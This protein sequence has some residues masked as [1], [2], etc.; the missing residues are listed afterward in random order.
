M[1]GSRDSSLGLWLEENTRRR[2]FLKKFV[3]TNRTKTWVQQIQAAVAFH[4]LGSRALPAAPAI[5]R[6]LDDPQCAPCAMI[7]LIYIHPKT[8]REIL[9]L[10]NVLRIKTGSRYGYQADSLHFGAILA[11]G[12][13]GTN[14]SAAIPLLCKMIA[15][16]N[17]NLQAASAVALQRVGVPPETG[18]PLI[19][20][21]LAQAKP[22]G[23]MFVPGRGTVTRAGAFTD[24][25][26][27]MQALERYG[28]HASNALPM[29]SNVAQAAY[30]GNIKGA[31]KVTIRAI[32]MDMDEASK[33]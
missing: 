10:T 16:T 31:A 3:R 4:E 20:K 33:K 13:F 6:L 24:M 25:M 15:S 27:M 23:T 19:M 8:E 5:T 1:L 32:T 17:Q 9:S 28:R 2:P 26:L 7:S 21:S 30:V 12:A 29:L 18:V 22:S 11:L 14:A